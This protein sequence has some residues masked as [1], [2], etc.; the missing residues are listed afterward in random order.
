MI[1]G[2]AL[3]PEDER[4]SARNGQAARRAAAAPGVLAVYASTNCAM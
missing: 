3:G 1:A 2:G 4:G